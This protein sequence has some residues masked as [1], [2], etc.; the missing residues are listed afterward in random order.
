MAYG[1][2]ST[3]VILYILSI[4]G[5]VIDASFAITFG[6][7]LAIPAAYFW[8]RVVDRFNNKKSM[9]IFSYAGLAFFLV[10]MFF[11]EN[12]LFVILLYGALSFVIGAN[13]TPLNMLVMENSPKD[14]WPA[15]FSK[16]QFIVSLGG[17]MGFALSTALLG[18]VS[19]RFLPL[20]FGLVAIPSIVMSMILIYEPARM[21]PRKLMLSNIHSF[22]TRVMMQPVLLIS[23]P[24]LSV[25]KIIFNIGNKMHRP[26]SYLGALYLAIFAFFISS[27]LFNTAYP[28]GLK[29]IG[30]TEFTIFL[31]ITIGI[32]IQVFTFAYFGNYVA[33]R[34]KTRMLPNAILLR[35]GSYIAIAFIFLTFTKFPGFIILNIVLYAI[36][37][38]LAYS[39]Y[40]TASNTL[41]FE[42]IGTEH[43]ASKLGIYTSLISVSFLL[44]ALLAGYI[45]YY[46]GYSASFVVAG[47]LLVASAFIFEGASSKLN[48]SAVDKQ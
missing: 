29:D 9:I 47:L 18:F 16:F 7:A 41:V 15:V 4:G 13:A 6:S 25:F 46:L 32:F 43:R 33:K 45:S 37:A 3:I 39:L 23:T 12:I 27:G 40:Y 26:K 44:G 38:G 28:V 48:A 19:I 2:V 5:N 34:I 36:G 31:I 30:L 11:T 42:A 24:K 14:Q 17:G 21:L 22:I 10:M 8:G 1:P 20:M 35:G